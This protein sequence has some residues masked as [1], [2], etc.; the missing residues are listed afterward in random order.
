MDLGISGRRVL[1]TGASQGIG[2]AIAKEFA[3]ESCK[4][5]LIA[6]RKEELERLVQEIGG[7]EKGH[8]FYSADLMEDDAPT[9]A[10][11]YL[12][13]K[14]G[15]YDIVVHNLGGTLEIRNPLSPWEDWERVLKYNA[16]ISIEMNK[17]FVPKMIEQNW[18]RI[19]NVSSLAA[20][21]LRGCAP[22][23]AA[24]A[25]L[26]AYTKALGKHLAKHNIIVSAVSPSSIY[27]PGGHWDPEKYDGEEKDKFLVKRA[28][29]MKHYCPR[30]ELG[31]AKDI[32]GL[33]VFLSSEKANMCGSGIYNL[34]YHEL[35][36]L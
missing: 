24:K 36:G 29:M 15:V 1:V 21:H 19:V 28:D 13:N 17:A 34:G 26:D 7:K 23:G 6:R 12:L 30:G 3:N 11:E 4:V 33:V 35:M 14:N 22:Y 27:A 25:F 5:T 9:K 16:G 20:Q 10:S 32:S 31:E 2:K 8:D 18:G